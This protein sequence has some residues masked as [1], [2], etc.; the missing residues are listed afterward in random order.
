MSYET[1]SPVTEVSST[2]LPAQLAADSTLQ[3]EG[4]YGGLILVRAFWKI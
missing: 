1:H 4:Q 2:G 3:N